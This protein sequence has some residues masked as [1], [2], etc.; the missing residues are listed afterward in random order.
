VS[1]INNLEGQIALVTGVSHTNGIGAAICRKLATEGADI[2]FT[3]WGSFPEWISSF[4]KEIEENG[5][6]CNNFEIDLSQTDSPYKLLDRV[7]TNLGLP[8][9]LINNAA[10]SVKD[11]Y[12]GLDAM[13]LDEHYRVNMRT[14]FLLSVEFARRFKK[15]NNLAGRIINMTSGQGLGPMPGELAYAATKGAISAFSFHYQ[16]NLHH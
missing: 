11:G 2:F 6:R 15:S 1:N 4:K 12:M 9:I 13:I 5:V 14:T 16:R 7:S 8:T 10:H 3:N